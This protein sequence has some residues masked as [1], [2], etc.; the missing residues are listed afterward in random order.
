MVIYFN[1]LVIPSFKGYKNIKEATQIFTRELDFSI[2]KLVE[3]IKSS[4]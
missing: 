4:Y 2:K 3:N 1:C